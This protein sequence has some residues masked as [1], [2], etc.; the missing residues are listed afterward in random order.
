MTTSQT[1]ALESLA[2]LADK[3]QELFDRVAQDLAAAE[4]WHQLFDLRL[5]QRRHE[6]GLPLERNSTLEDVDESL[7]DDLEQGYLAACREVGQLLLDKHQLREAWMYLRPASEKEM[8]RKYLESVVPN[9]D[10]CDAL[11][12]VSLHE[13]V[14]P[15]RGYAWLIANHGT[16]NSITTLDSLAGQLPEQQQESCAAVLLRHVYAELQGNMRGHLHRLEGEAPEGISIGELMQQFPA[17]TEG[18][19]Y[20]MDA[21]HLAST[22]RF[23]RLLTDPQLVKKAIEICEYGKHLI[24]DMQYPGEAPFEELYPT[25]ELFLRATLGERVDEAIEFFTRRAREEQAAEPALGVPTNTAVETLLVLLNRNE[26]YAEAMELYAELVP[27]DRALS[28]LSP[29]LLE[30]ATQSGDWQ[31]YEALCSER[32]DIVGYA[33]GRALQQG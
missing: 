6:L 26:R 9:E 30:L 22:V 4:Q 24:E 8:V 15:E 25:H 14:D 16:C 3:P 10:N 12:E 20:H 2:E 13:G 5:M 18:G 21:S 27:T 23:A 11:I 28:P 33:A 29:T 7:R 32:N 17:L 1:T 31:R 19:S